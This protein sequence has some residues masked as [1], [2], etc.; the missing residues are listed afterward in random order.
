LRG[1]TLTTG[2][3]V[4]VGVGVDEGSV[5]VNCTEALKFAVKSKAM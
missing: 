4:V 1:K 2:C 3:G 5:T